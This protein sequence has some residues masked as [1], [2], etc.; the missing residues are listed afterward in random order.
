MH[1]TDVVK[2]VAREQRL[3]QR[4]VSDV[5]GATHRLI[6]ETLRDGKSVT[7]PGFGSFQTSQ[8]QGG[9]IKH[10]R[11]GE[12]IE[13]HARVIATFRPGEVLKRAARG[14]NRRGGSARRRKQK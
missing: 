10:V 3:S 7:F 11:T 14:E 9:K 5:L 13:Y 12:L 4:I 6:E 2:R 8:R 1:K